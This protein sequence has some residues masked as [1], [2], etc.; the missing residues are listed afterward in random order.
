MKILNRSFFLIISMLIV[1]SCS[2]DDAVP[3]LPSPPSLV[4]YLKASDI[5]NVMEKVRQK[6]SL[7]S[8]GEFG[9]NSEASSSVGT[10]DLD[11]YYKS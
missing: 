8:G 3:E 4:N 5:P 9:A 10:I 7:N 11:K 6:I 1:F 2:V